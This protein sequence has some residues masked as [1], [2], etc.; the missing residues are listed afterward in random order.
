[1][2]YWE[3]SR[4]RGRGPTGKK[5]RAARK[6]GGALW[7]AGG[8]L[9]GVASS[10]GQAGGGELRTSRASTQ[11]LTVQRKKTRRF[12]KKPPHFGGFSRKNKTAPFFYYLVIQ[13]TLKFS[14]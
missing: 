13:T 8:A 12:C 1:M 14:K 10:L 3:V 4:E 9:E 6:E 5:S 2:D 7:R 11:L